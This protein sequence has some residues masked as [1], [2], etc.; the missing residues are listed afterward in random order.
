MNVDNNQT[1]THIHIE[2]GMYCSLV[3]FR[4]IIDSI[5]QWLFYTDIL[6]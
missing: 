3:R 2:N 6:T 5:N 4:Y 1:N